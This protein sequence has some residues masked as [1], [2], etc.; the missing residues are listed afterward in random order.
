MEDTR[1]FKVTLGLGHI[2]NVLGPVY[3]LSNP[4]EC[5][6]LPE[7]TDSLVLGQPSAITFH[8]NREKYRGTTE[9]VGPA[10]RGFPVYLRLRKKVRQLSE[11][12]WSL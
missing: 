11:D 5:S 4:W 7:R 3:S 1:H 10:S 12:R 8:R 2:L 9:A 6:L